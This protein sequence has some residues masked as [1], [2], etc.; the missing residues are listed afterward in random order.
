MGLRRQVIFTGLLEDPV[1]IY[2][3]LDLYVSASLKEGLPLSV[4]EAMGAGL[5]VV[6]TDV[7]G[8][9]DVVVHGKTGMLVPSE[10]PLALAGAISSLL[11]DPER[12]RRMG[13]AGRRR[14]QEEFMIEPMVERTAE[15]YR[16]AARSLTE[17]R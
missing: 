12:R 10:D 7:P 17:R 8:H 1:R 13:E 11:A 2:P 3:A 9:R 16:R 6:A 5:A 4:V 15:V 14:A